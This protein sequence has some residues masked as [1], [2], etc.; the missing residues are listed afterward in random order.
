MTRTEDA[1]PKPI[2]PSK[3]RFRVR[4]CKP[5]TLERTSGVA[6]VLR[7]HILCNGLPLCK[8]TPVQSRFRR[9]Q[10]SHA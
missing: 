7:E 3:F 10:K 4:I 9:C 6:D 2:R 8:G 1:L 5:V